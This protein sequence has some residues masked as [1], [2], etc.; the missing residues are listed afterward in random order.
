MSR[1]EGQS[2]RR[3][4]ILLLAGYA[5]LIAISVT[6]LGAWIHERAE[7]T[8]WRAVLGAALQRTLGA[9]RAAR[10]SSRSGSESIMSFRLL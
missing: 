9:L 5:T 7:H 8:V 10:S 4:L 6:V 2:L 1:G 3:M